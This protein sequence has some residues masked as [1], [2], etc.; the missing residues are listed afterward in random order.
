MKRTLLIGAL[1]ILV[2]VASAQTAHISLN[3]SD[4]T[5]FNGIIDFEDPLPRFMKGPAATFELNNQKAA[6]SVPISQPHY[7]SITCVYSN[8][9]RKYSD[10]SITYQVFLSPGDDL[11]LNLNLAKG[12]NGLSAT[13]RGS[14]N[15]QPDAGRFANIFSG[16]DLRFDKSPY[17]II[18]VI[19]QQQQELKS[20]L[21][22]YIKKNKPTAAFVNVNHFNV[23]YY[24][25]NKYFFVNNA[26]LDPAHRSGPWKKIQDSVLSSVK[27]NND[28]A[29]ISTNYKSLIN[30][31]TERTVAFLGDDAQTAPV[32]FYTEWYNTDTATGKKLFAAERKNVFREK[33]IDRY[34]SGKTAEYVDYIV[35]RENLAEQEFH[36][37]EKMYAHFKERYPNSQYTAQFKAPIEEYIEKSKRQLT[38]KMVFAAN[39]GSK[40]KTV[41]ELA[42]AFKGKTVFVD[43]WGTWCGPCREEIDQKSETIRNHFKGKDV[44]F[45]Y[46]SNRDIDRADEWK[47]LIAYYKMEGAHILADMSL[48]KDIM[49]QL[50]LTG[51]PSYFIINKNGSVK[52]T[53][54][55][56]G[57]DTQAMEGEI[58]A[59]L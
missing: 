50:K 8:G 11:R 48:T 41:A 4:R 35:I 54:N 51:F 26:Q 29:L 1:A 20:L 33:V 46:I 44:V 49:D 18:A 2:K 28:D 39:N 40:L 13:G 25:A 17:T 45:L 36:G 24:A 10:K 3:I 7:V 12:E 9:Q 52:A 6:S 55:Q 31:F 58:S 47:R 16:R 27:L 23:M 59:A 34:F 5:K 53:K 14:N 19:N 43:M 56:Y 42:A 57:F 22:T 15:N 32:K 21:E 30:D 38:N 37:I